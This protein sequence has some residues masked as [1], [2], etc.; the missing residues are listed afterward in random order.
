MSERIK[1]TSKLHPVDEDMVRYL[2]RLKA[3]SLEKMDS[4]VGIMSVQDKILNT[5]EKIISFMNKE[6]SNNSYFYIFLGDATERNLKIVCSSVVNNPD[7]VKSFAIRIHASWLDF[8]VDQLSLSGKM[9]SLIH[10][11]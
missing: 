1:I 2:F 5:A 4:N 6:S 7:E 8:S 9:L 10:G 3:V 11:T